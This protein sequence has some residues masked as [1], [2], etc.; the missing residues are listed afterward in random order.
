MGGAAVTGGLALSAGGLGWV[1]ATLA[2]TPPLPPTTTELAGSTLAPLVPAGGLLLLAA[3]VAVL[4][5]RGAGRVAVGLLVAAAGGVLAWSGLRPL[6]SDLDAAV[7]AALDAGGALSTDLHPAGPVLALVAGAGALA[8]GLLTVLRGR[9]W[10]GMG[11]RHER[12]A[13]PAPALRAR[14]DE[15]RAVD[16]WRALD[17][18]EDPTEPAAAGEEQR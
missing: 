18:G 1:T 14:T 3:A 16:A 5:V 9:G 4:A 6:V 7:A 2:R 15:D 11:R 8:T 13:G 10:P 17:R 12:P